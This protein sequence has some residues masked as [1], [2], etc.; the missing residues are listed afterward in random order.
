MAQST[1]TFK[2]CSAQILPVSIYKLD[3]RTS[4]PS[5]R[6]SL[7]AAA[8]RDSDVLQF[9]AR[10]PFRSRRRHSTPARSLTMKS[11]TSRQISLAP[12]PETSTRT[13]LARNPTLLYR[14][15]RT[16]ITLTLTSSWS[17]MVSSSV[18][19]S[20]VPTQAAS[21]GVRPAKNAK[22][23]LSCAFRPPFSCPSSAPPR[24]WPCRDAS[25][26]RKG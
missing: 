20:V 26:R 7:H 23:T 10:V 12:N 2:I 3:V 16:I 9:H 15:Y 4:R 8:S 6:P 22:W 24:N 1:R 21:I 18:H 5:L 25:L 11:A 14:P 19:P 13:Q 17:P